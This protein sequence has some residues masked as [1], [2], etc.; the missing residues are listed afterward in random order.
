MLSWSVLNVLEYFSSLFFQEIQHLSALQTS[1]RFLPSVIT[2][3][4]LNVTTGL[5][6]HKFRADY[7]VT[8]SSLLSAVSPLLMAL[9]NP[10]WPYW[11]SAFW[12]MLVSP[13]SADSTYPLPFSTFY[14]L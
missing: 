5:F 12:V 11:Y 3:L 1:I 2:G 4:I 7:L 9:I 6:A 13:L 8:I 10:K 14:I